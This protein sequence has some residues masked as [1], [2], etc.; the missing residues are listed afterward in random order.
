MA[1]YG[2]LY[3]T[4]SARDIKFEFWPLSDSGHTQP[5]DLFTVDLTT[6]VLTGA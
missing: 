5:Y 6:H 2:Y 4:V 1:S 3:P